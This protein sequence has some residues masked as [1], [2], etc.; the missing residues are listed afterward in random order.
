MPNYVSML[1]V[2]LLLFLMPVGGLF[3]LARQSNGM[4]S[5][6]TGRDKLS[7]GPEKPNWVS[8]VTSKKAH[9]IEAIA[10]SGDPEVAWSKIQEA[11]NELGNTTP[12]TTE[13]DYAHFECRTP[14]LG[15]VDDLELLLNPGE[16]RIEIRSASR[17][18]H[19]DLGANRK[20]VEKLRVLFGERS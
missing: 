8:S 13:P 15:F 4:D 9:Q 18:G 19:S 14:L 7:E 3:F 16:Q 6:A 20:R 10:F 11:L 12:V 5:E 2:L 17:A 1:L